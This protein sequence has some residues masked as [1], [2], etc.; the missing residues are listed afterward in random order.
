MPFWQT[1]LS[2]ESNP[3]SVPRMFVKGI[4]GFA[5]KAMDLQAPCQVQKGPM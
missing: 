2:R 5:Q 3:R 4:A 1:A